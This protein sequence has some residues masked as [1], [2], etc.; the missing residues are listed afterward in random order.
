[1]DLVIGP[2]GDLFYVDNPGG[3]VHRVGLS[4]DY[5]FSDSFETG[6]FSAWSNFVK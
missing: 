2:G 6:D 5:V 1:M 4:A 3:A